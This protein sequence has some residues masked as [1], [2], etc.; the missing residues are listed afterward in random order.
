[1]PY[2]IIFAAVGL[3]SAALLALWQY[4]NIIDRR[5]DA[6]EV[7][8]FIAMGPAEQLS[9]LA[10]ARFDRSAACS[11]FQHMRKL[12]RGYRW[13][14]RRNPYFIPYVV[15]EFE[16]ARAHKRVL[17]LEDI[18]GHGDAAAA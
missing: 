12:W 11:Y 15:S 7:A 14:Y 3:V 1:M 5:R 9:A 4:M 2:I 13:G 16:Y 8:S 6:A 18:I 10:S 17:R